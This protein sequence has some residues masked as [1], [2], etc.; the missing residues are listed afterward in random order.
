MG[1]KHLHEMAVELRK[2]FESIWFDSNDKF[3]DKFNDKQYQIYA[4]CRGLVIGDR[5]ENA[6]F[7]HSNA[8]MHRRAFDY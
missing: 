3:N 1:R 6:A 4:K 7:H 2:K 5:M 8:T